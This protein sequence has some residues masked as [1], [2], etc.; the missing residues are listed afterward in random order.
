[1]T[2]QHSYEKVISQDDIES[3]FDGGVDLKSTALETLDEDMDDVPHQELSS[4]V[5]NSTHEMDTRS[6]QW[7]KQDNSNSAMEQLRIIVSLGWPNC[8]ERFV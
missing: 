7:H 6:N 1:M 8:I 3:S 4:K 5:F 2:S